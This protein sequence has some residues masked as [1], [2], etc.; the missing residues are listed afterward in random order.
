MTPRNVAWFRPLFHDD[1]LL[2]VSGARAWLDIMDQRL[3][4]ALVRGG[5]YQAIQAF[6][7]DLIWAGCALLYCERGTRQL[8]RFESCQ[9]GTFQ[10]ALDHE[11]RLAAVSRELRMSAASAAEAFGK[12][13]LS[14]TARKK[15]ERAPH[16]ELQLTQFVRRDKRGRFPYSSLWW[17]EGGRDFLRQSG[18]HEMPFFFTSWHRSASPYGSGP[19]DECLPDARQ[20]DRLE[21]RKMAAIGK[22]VDPPLLVN[23]PHLKD[24]LEFGPGAINYIGNGKQIV[25][26][27]DL[28]P[29]AQSLPQIQAEIQNVQRR[30]QDGLMATIFE[31]MPLGQRPRDM[32]ATEFLERKREAMQ[33]LGPV[34]SAYEPD[35]L[36]PVLERAAF[37][38]DRAG[39]IPP[40]PDEL[41]DQNLLMKMDFI[42]PMANALRQSGAESTR[43]LLQEVIALSR[44]SGV[45][46]MLDKLDLDQAVDELATGLG[47]PGAIVRSDEDVQKLRQQRQQEQA[48]QQQFEQARQALEL[49]RQAQ[50]VSSRQQEKGA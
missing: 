10:I 13:R 41:R 2:E 39:L 37:C 7:L 40:V 34:I 5:F 27:L 1:R 47:V 22:L 36:T 26:L 44:E 17:E 16:E 33:L 24:D 29:T 11:G 21:R 3:K 18:F 49:T 38:L 45:A 25:P 32:S 14:E 15:L 42:S 12:D 9:I 50:D 28:G 31:T 6:N 20:I 35:V 43:G 23:D 4:D 46:P 48:S 30:L 19:G 8:L